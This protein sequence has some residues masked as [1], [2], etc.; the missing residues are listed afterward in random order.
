MKKIKMDTRF[1]LDAHPHTRLN[2]LTGEWIL[3]SPQRN[4]RPWQGK[5]EESPLAVRNAYEDN[6]LV[7]S[8]QKGICKVISFSPQHHLTLPELTVEQITGVVNTWRKEFIKLAAVEC[9]TV[10]ALDQLFRL[11]ISDRK[12]YRE[13]QYSIQRTIWYPLRFL[14]RDDRYRCKH[15]R[16][17][18]NYIWQQ[19]EVY[20]GH[21]KIYV[22]L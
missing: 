8:N 6:L 18:L 10:F 22:P 21:R 13:G 14:C 19:K 20:A 11:N 9:A 1:K 2:I 12:F 15:F 4:K 16:L 7:A 5:L 17:D 3:V